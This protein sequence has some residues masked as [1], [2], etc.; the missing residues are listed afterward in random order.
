MK[1]KKVLFFLIIG[2]GIALTSCMSF[3]EAG[4]LNMVSCRNI[5]THAKYKLLKKNVEYTKKELKRVRTTTIESAVDEVVK[6]VDGGEYLMNAKI[7]VCIVS[8]YGH[9]TVYYAVEGDVWGVK[10]LTIGDL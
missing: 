9:S 10:S 2:T 4:R 5:D 6:K 1:T 3:K 8:G 7:K